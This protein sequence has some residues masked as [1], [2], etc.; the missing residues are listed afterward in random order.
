MG[1][2][3]SPNLKHGDYAEISM[4]TNMYAHNTSV[5]SNLAVNIKS[6]PKVPRNLRETMQSMNHHRI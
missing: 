2:V 4:T 3:E 1:S 5:M 6:Q